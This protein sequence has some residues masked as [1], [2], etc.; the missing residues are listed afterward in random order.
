MSSGQHPR[1]DVQQE[2]AA[3]LKRIDGETYK[4]VLEARGRIWGPTAIELAEM[5][6]GGESPVS[7]RLRKS[8][9]LVG[10]A[11]G[12]FAEAMRKIGAL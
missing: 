11:F 2:F 5:A 12:T 10:R 4:R 3:A 8:Y 9:E 1:L 6:D 7:R